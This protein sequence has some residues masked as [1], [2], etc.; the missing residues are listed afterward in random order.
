M[1]L[2]QSFAFA[3]LAMAPS[4]MAFTSTLEAPNNGQGTHQLVRP[5]TTR[6]S[7][8]A[9]PYTN[10]HS[11]YYEIVDVDGD[12]MSLLSLLDPPVAPRVDIP[13][14]PEES[15]SP[16]GSVGRASQRASPI[17]KLQ[18][19]QDY[20]RHVLNEPNQLCIIRF[21]APWCKVCKSTSVSWERMASKIMKTVKNDKRRIKFFSVSLDGKDEKT[22]LLKDM[23][24]VRR[25]PQGIIHHPTQGV[26]GQRVDLNRSNLSTLKKKLETYLEDGKMGSGS[27]LDGLKRE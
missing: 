21:S 4:A 15:E 11:S 19:I 6:L 10:Y 18:S 24:Q 17:I 27:L 12:R 26:F 14:Q 2:M 1:N 5:Q 20:H 9:L 16:T 23:L 25:I 3:S 22:V 7:I 8:T 13:S